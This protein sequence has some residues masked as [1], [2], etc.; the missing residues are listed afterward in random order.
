MFILIMENIANN[1]MYAV[2]ELHIFLKSF[3]VDL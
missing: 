2:Q 3:K 1:T